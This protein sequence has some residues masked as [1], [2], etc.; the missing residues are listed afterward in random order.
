[1]SIFSPAARFA[2]DAHGVVDGRQVA[3][4]ELDV[5]HGADDL[6]D[7]ADLLRIHSCFRCQ[8]QLVAARALV[9]TRSKSPA[10]PTRL[11]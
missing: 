6:D 3:A 10:R 2:D 8:L 7:L 11:R 5:H 1:M 9:L 4:L